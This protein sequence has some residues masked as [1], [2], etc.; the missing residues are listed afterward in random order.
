MAKDHNYVPPRR[1]DYASILDLDIDR[2]E[3]LTEDAPIVTFFRILLQQVISF[4]WY[5]LTNI[6]AS[7]TSLPKEKSNMPLG[8]SHV[9]PY[10]SLFRPDEAHVII[11]SDIGLLAMGYVLYLASCQIGIGLV[12]LLYFQPY[13][14]LNHWIV[15][16]TYL[17]HTHPD[18][19]K[20]EE[21]NWTFLKGATS[22]VDREF[23][24]IGKHIFHNIIEFHVI[25]HLFS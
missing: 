19:P 21:T 14:W 23:G 22:T 5:L 8:N 1:Q 12:A 20:F 13:V 6:T 25:H 9:A 11:L 17:H 3:E 7:A 10:G 2:L 18:I 16:I 4:P 15:A 24:F